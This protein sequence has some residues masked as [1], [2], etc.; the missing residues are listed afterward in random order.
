MQR[1][2]PT[3][4]NPAQSPVMSPDYNN[5]SQQNNNQQPIP[6]RMNFQTSAI[7]QQPQ[8]WNL[9]QN[10]DAYN[11]QTQPMVKQQ[12]I[13]KE[14]PPLPEEFIYMQTVFEELKN[15]CSGLQTDPVSRLCNMFYGYFI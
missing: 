15:Q 3:M 8:Q 11:K 12:E 13:P 7:Q 5:P 2:P 14:K 10:A 9:N 6:N 1:P 4:I